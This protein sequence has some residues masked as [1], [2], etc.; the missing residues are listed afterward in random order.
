[1]AKTNTT[2]YIILGLLDHEDLSG[3]D[4]KKRIDYMISH[5]WEVGYGQ[6]YPTLKTMEENEMIIK[7]SI[8]AN[9]G[10]ERNLYS[11]TEKGREVLREWLLLP[12]DKEYTKY[13]ILVKLFF[14]NMVTPDENLKRIGAFR[15][16]Q[17]KNAEMIKLFKHNLEQV[18]SEDEDHLYYYLTVLFGEKVYRA[19]QDWAA[20]AETLLEDYN[21]Q[22][23]SM[24]KSTSQTVTKE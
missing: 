10:P 3:Y 14:G 22:K 4:I 15:E 8:E 2:V 16:R 20:E 1:M 11:I 9:K 17:N 7:Q 18:L 5:F 12:E 23:T 21:R 13:E 24:K 6:I 19:Y